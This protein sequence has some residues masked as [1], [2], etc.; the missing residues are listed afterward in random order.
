MKFFPDPAAAIPGSTIGAVDA[1]FAGLPDVE[2]GEATVTV[3]VVP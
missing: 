1:A 2:V 3:T